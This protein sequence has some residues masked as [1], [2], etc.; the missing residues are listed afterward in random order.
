MN[1]VKSDIELTDY[2][3]VVLTF[4]MLNSLNDVD[5]LDFCINNGDTAFH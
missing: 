1:S 2:K 5:E 4:K 3:V